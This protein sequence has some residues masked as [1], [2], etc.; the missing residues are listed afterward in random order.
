V[1]FSYSEDSGSEEALWP[2]YHNDG[3]N[4]K[5]HNSI[6]CILIVVLLSYVLFHQSVL[7]PDRDPSWVF[8]REMFLKPYFMLSGEV[9][10][11][12]IIPQCD[13]DTDFVVCHMGRWISF[14]VTVIYLFICNILT[15]NLL[16][17]VPNNI[18]DEVSAVSDQVWMFQRFRVVMEDKKKPVLPPPL[19]VLCRDFLLFRY[20]HSKVH[21]IQES[22]GNALKLFLDPD[23]RE[24][25]CRFEEEC[26]EITW[27]SKKQSRTTQ[28]MSI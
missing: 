16:I 4:V 24:Y 26:I 14:V 20:F 1:V 11:Q 23:D 17:A 2:P 10:T 9:L 12:S 19:T 25:L 6:F 3:H 5:G 27:K 22:Y 8:M 15:L 18:F 28:M 7:H 13:N 21:G